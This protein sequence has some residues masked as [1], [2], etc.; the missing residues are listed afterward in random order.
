MRHILVRMSRTPSDADKAAAHDKALALRKQIQDGKD[1]AEVAKE[2]SDDPASKGQGGEL[3]WNERSS[4]VPAFAQAAFNLKVGELSEPVL[5]PFGWHLVQVEE[6]KPAEEKP[7]AS[8]S[9]DIAQVLVKRQ[10]AA[11]LAEADAKK[12]AAA[13]QKGRIARHPVPGQ[14]GRGRPERR[15]GREAPGGGHRQLP[16]E[17]HR[18]SSHRARAR[19]CWPR[20]SPWAGPGRFP[21]PFRAGDSFVVAEVTVREIAR[22]REPGWR[23]RPRSA[24]RRSASARPSCRSPTWRR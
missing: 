4:F 17:R 23:R 10:R 22:R 14:E 21:G 16:Q 19:S 24:R 6:K 5:T 7:L 20:P 12:A 13:V 18:H 15:A 2:S 3:G 9:N 11:A 1:F 8:V